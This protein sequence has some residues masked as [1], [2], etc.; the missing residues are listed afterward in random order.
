MSR[1]KSLKRTKQG[2]ERPADLTFF[3]STSPGQ[4]AGPDEVIMHRTVCPARLK[5]EF[6]STSAGRLLRPG[7]SENG[8]GTMTTS[9]C[10]ARIGHHLTAEARHRPAMT[11]LRLL[12]VLNVCLGTGTW[13]S[14]RLLREGAAASEEVGPQLPVPLG[15]CSGN[16]AP[17]SARLVRTGLS[18]T[19]PRHVARKAG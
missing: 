15:F 7:R 18:R 11:S 10:L 13:R 2:T 19:S 5:D 4:S 6:V 12:A 3:S 17:S 16:W 14:D 8:N 9:H 1:V